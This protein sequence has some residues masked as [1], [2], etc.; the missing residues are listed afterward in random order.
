MSKDMKKRKRKVCCWKGKEINIY[1]ML[2]TCQAPLYMSSLIYIPIT[3]A[4]NIQLGDD[5]TKFLRG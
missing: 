1:Y 2:T 3:E 4:N 5:K